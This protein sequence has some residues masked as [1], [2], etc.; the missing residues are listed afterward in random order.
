MPRPALLLCLSTAVC[1]YGVLFGDAV[2]ATVQYSGSLFDEHGDPVGGGYVIVGTFA[3]GFD[4]Y[5]GGNEEGTRYNCVYGDSVCNLNSGAYD[6]AVSDG[7]FIPIGAGTI[8]ML[9]GGFFGAG[10]TSAPAGTPIWLFAFEDTSR[11]SFF[12][13]LATSSTWQVPGQPPGFASL[14]AS[15]ADLFVMGTSHPLGVA[16]S[17]I[18]FPEPC[19]LTFAV[20]ACMGGLGVRGISGLTW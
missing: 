18:P 4:P 14:D 15:D 13:V 3:P 16:L 5:N 8:T 10:T 7:N 9:Q 12:Q 20:M 11:D 1:Q 19:S 2:G 6:S 17:V